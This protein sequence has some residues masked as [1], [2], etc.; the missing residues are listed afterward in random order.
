MF[1]SS[2]HSNSSSYSSKEETWAS[3]NSINVEAEQQPTLRSFG[4]FLL[5]N[6]NLFKLY[7]CSLHIF[8][9]SIS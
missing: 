5:V 7:I 9:L 8:K 4:Q 2:F 1:T 6:I 3:I